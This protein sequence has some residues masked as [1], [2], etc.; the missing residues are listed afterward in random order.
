MTFSR[1]A[2]A[3]V[4]TLGG[5]HLAATSASAGTLC[6]VV[7]DAASGSVVSETG[8][9]RTQVTPASTF[10]LALAVIG[11]DEGFLVDEQ[12][13]KLPFRAGY[14]DWMGAEWRQDTTPKR[15]M[16]HSVVWYSQQITQALGRQKV[17]SYLKGFSYG[18]A[19]LSG[20]PGKDNGLERGWISSSLKISPRE[21]IAF[22]VRFLKRDLPVKP[23]TYAKAEA[24]VERHEVADG[25]TV[26]GKTGSAF[27]RKVDGS[28]DRAN[29][30]G[31]YVGW[32][33]KGNR[34]L[35]FA[36]LDQGNK[37]SG[38]SVRDEMLRN[39]PKA[40]GQGS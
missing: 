32:A 34:T 36:R 11:Y 33:R 10:K 8:D 14:A 2:A 35:A 3:I 30:W 4:F 7:A 1:C 24:I 31:W 37:V 20:D 19:D 12:L 17:E 9:C 5:L 6:S 39:W 21:E 26:W 29:G 38:R 15:W 25:W 22:L 23:A 27:P 16:K 28:F 40:V 13:P 18:N